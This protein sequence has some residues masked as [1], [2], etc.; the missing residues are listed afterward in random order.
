LV[1]SIG[2]DHVIDY[3]QEDFTHH[4]HRYD[5][6]L[7]NVMNHSLSDCRRALTADGTLILN[8][9][10]GGGRWIGT[11][12]R[13]GLAFV[14]SRFIRQRVRLAG[15]PSNEDLPVLKERIE[16]GEMRPVVD[17]TYPLSQTAEAL[18]YLGSG[19]ARGKVIIAV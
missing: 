11:L 17:R 12:G 14:L 4:E 5:L 2:A 6:I 18:R 1:R 7:D 16:A 13:M 19:H 9:G 10:T 3:T 15:L 8:N